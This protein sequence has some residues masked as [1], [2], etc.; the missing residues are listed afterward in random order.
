MISIREVF[1]R[2]LKFGIFIVSFL[3]L[4]TSCLPE[5]K[6]ANTLIQSPPEINILV[7]APE[8]VF[9]YNH[10]GEM[11]PGFDSIGDAQQDSALWV[12]SS[13]VQY[14]NDSLLLEKYINSFINELRLLGFNVYLDNSIDSFLIGK[15]QS[16]VWNIAQIQVDEYLYPLE[17][18]EPFQD[19]VYYKRFDLNA[20]DFSCWFEL[21]KVNAEKAHKLTLYSSFTAYDNFEGEFYLDPWEMDMKYKYRLDSLQVKDVTEMAVYS[22]RKHAAYL[23]DYFLNQFIAARLPKGQTMYY[24]YHYNRQKKSV[25]PTDDTGFEVIEPK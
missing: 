24:Y 11:I 14:L 18:E 8:V 7:F 2:A 22:G 3:F 12:E 23:Y 21:S 16:Y 25:S 4:L 17:D 20:V 13:Y 10:K 1:T 19:T 15:P 5:Q 9:K 6:I